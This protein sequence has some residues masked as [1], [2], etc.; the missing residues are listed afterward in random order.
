MMVSEGMLEMA[1]LALLLLVLL[2]ARVHANEGYGTVTRTPAASST[3]ALT[4]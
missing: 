2:E 4:S 3:A 1:G